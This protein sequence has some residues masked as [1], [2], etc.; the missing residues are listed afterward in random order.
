MH[1]PHVHVLV[2]G[3]RLP[4]V[5]TRAI[6]RLG[7]S[8]S[9]ARLNDAIRSGARSHADAVVIVEAAEAAQQAITQAQLR[10][11]VGPRCGALIVSESPARRCVRAP[12]ESFDVSADPEES[13]LAG[14]IARLIDRTTRATAAIADAASARR[15]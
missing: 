3:D 7:A 15:P 10:R 4:G 8:A 2:S 12:I 9:F 14:R 6:A 13:H 5:L 11:I 1:S